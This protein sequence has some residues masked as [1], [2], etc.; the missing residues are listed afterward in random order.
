MAI[1]D[2][3][4]NELIEKKLSELVFHKNSN[5]HKIFFNLIKG[6]F[7]WIDKK[8]IFFFT[9]DNYIKNLKT[10]NIEKL[11]FLNKNE[12]YQIFWINNNN[13]FNEFRDDTNILYYNENENK[14]YSLIIDYE[15][16]TD[17]FLKWKMISINVKKSFDKFFSFNWNYLL[18]EIQNEKRKLNEINNKNEKYLKTLILYF[19][20]DII[21][22]NLKWKDGNYIDFWT[23]FTT[24]LKYWLEE[25]KE[26]KFY[27]YIDWLNL[28]NS[29]NNYILSIW[30]NNI[31]KYLLNFQSK[32]FKQNNII[33][34]R[35]LFT[36]QINDLI[37]KRKSKEFETYN[38]KK[39]IINNDDYLL[40][41]ITNYFNL[42]LKWKMEFYSDFRVKSSDWIIK[43]LENN[44]SLKEK[45]AIEKLSEKK[46]IDELKLFKELLNNK[47]KYPTKFAFYFKSNL[48]NFFKNKL[49]KKII[50]QIK[51][52]DN[53][54][55][56]EIINE[57]IKQES[58]I[59]ENTNIKN[60][61][62]N[63]LNIS[64]WI[65]KINDIEQKKKRLSDIKE[66]AKWIWNQNKKLKINNKEFEKKV[67]LNNNN[68][69]NFEIDNLTN[70]EK[71]KYILNNLNN[72]I[73]YFD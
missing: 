17:Y 45:K 54:K 73:T 35:Y 44:I 61:N 53:I 8:N 64:K 66:I 7:K 40:I 20:D 62:L 11:D 31:I 33:Q 70:I 3:L 69:N 59:K 19:L 23:I 10:W 21:S 39:I 15:N 68:Y 22:Y 67:L 34:K 56:D 60:E 12:N 25:N 9:N 36:F 18:N 13:N 4:E 37:T 42:C 52:T 71:T 49:Y 50:E 38:W 57:Y 24:I 2:W 16:G 29:Y 27:S 30:L 63:E 55:K 58:K 28:K 41:N 47:Y 48:E 5:I 65:K 46:L 32:I 6:E 43:N 14:I 72:W 1:V 26:W 51:N